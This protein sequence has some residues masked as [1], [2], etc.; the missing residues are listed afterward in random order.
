MSNL[1]S[2]C[3]Q[4]VPEIRASRCVKRC[5]TQ[6]RARIDA[7]TRLCELNSIY[8]RSVKASD[9]GFVAGPRNF[10]TL[11]GKTRKKVDYSESEYALLGWSGI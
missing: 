3:I 9:L 10:T 1:F 6:S 8:R 4:Y 11:C 5:V 7:S 2:A